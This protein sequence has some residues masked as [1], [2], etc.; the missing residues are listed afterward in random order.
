MNICLLSR[1]FHCRKG[2]TESYPYNM[3]FALSKAGHKVHIICLNSGSFYRDIE[4]P[5]SIFVHDI[6]FKEDPFAGYWRIN[7]IILIDD[8]RY[9]ML[10]AKKI[11]ELIR[12][13]SIDIVESGDGL[14]EGYWY[15]LK[16]QVPLVVRLHG[17]HGIP[18]DAYKSQLKNHIFRQKLMFLMEKKLISNADSISSVSK[19]YSE[20]ART[21]YSIKKEI[22]TIHNGVREDVFKASN[23]KERDYK[24]V[25]FVGWLQES[26]GLGVLAKAIP[27]VLEKRPDVNFILIGKD[28]RVKGLQKT[29]REYLEDRVNSKNIE[30]IYPVE[31][32]ELAERYYG[33]S[34][35]CVFPSLYEPGGT[36]AQE[37]MMC[38]CPV[39]A[40]RVGGFCEF[41][42]DREDGILIPPGDVGALSDA[43]LDL[44][45]DIDLRRQ[46]GER[47]STKARSHF[48]L[49]N[50]TVAT[51]ELY[52]KTIECFKNNNSCRRI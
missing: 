13:F 8:L 44:L 7:R 37:A 42:K 50:I 10:V 9:S 39:V 25:L 1:N 23:F 20:L 51:I 41:I 4:K 40:T 43:I 38:G 27:I 48:S 24:T 26:K 2:G 16:K 32:K 11:Y 31:Q 14:A 34:T 46:I 18:I 30:F 5:G 36:V 33:K 3:A 45:S 6:N 47:A 22:V 52:S 17:H 15:S 21:L 49:G 29:W 28:T 12:E 19:N 35:I